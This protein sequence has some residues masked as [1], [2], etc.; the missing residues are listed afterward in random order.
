MVPQS[1]MSSYLFVLC[2]PYSGSTLLWKLLST[3]ANVSAMPTEGQFLPELEELMRDKPWD[4][5]HPLPWPEIKRVWESYWD[6]DKPILLEK[7]PPN[8]IRAQDIQA[9]FQPVKFIVMVRNPYAHCE[10]LMRRNHWKPARAA[11]FSMMCL[12]TQ[13]QNTQDLD[14]ALVLTYESLVQNPA[15]VCDQLAA[16]VPE[17]GDIDHSADFEVH[18]IDGTVNRPITDLNSKKIASLP[19]DALATMNEIFMQQRET[20]DAWEYPLLAPGYQESE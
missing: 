8:I 20:L 10:G 11:N 19:A 7:S 6:K 5:N 16:F 12:R 14:N 15:R 18:S 13:L 1:P 3:S 2:P 4:A 17:L 9:H